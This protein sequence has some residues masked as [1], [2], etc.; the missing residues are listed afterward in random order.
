[1]YNIRRRLEKIDWEMDADQEDNLHQLQ[2]QMP[3]NLLFLRCDSGARR[4]DSLV[5]LWSSPEL[6]DF[7]AQ[8]GHERPI[9]F[10]PTAEL[11]LKV[12]AEI[13]LGWL[14]E[15]LL[16]T[17]HPASQGLINESEEMID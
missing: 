9:F 7:A 6:L 12:T 3:H 15:M 5:A 1:M 16:L 13:G 2:H 17:L 8:A 14:R 10:D 4:W 11:G